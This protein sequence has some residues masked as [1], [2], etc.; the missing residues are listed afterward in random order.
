MRAALT[1]LALLVSGGGATDALKARDAEVRAALPPPGQ[2]LGPEARQRIEGIFSRAVDVDGMVATAMGPRW[3]S[4]T[5]K[6]RK[7]LLAAFGKRLRQ[8]GGENLQGYR[9]AEIEYRSETASPDGTVHV[10]TRV[11]AKGEPT[12]VVY[13]MRRD[14]DAWRIVDIVVDGVSTVENY[15]AS[16]AR[17][18]AKEGVEGLIRR[19]ERGVAKPG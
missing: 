8:A 3:K 12:D 7:R 10:P 11:V 16:F 18:I 4:L 1:L 2:P 15:R 13:L 14:G 19:F 6:Q 17:V 5:P 9:S